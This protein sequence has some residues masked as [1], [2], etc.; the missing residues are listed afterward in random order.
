MSVRLR[1]ALRL[2]EGAAAQQSTRRGGVR[3]GVRTWARCPRRVSGQRH[4]CVWVGRAAALARA[5]HADAHRPTH[6]H[7]LPQDP[8][9]GIAATAPVRP[10][11]IA[12]LAK[13]KAEQKALMKKGHAKQTGTNAATV[14][15]FINLKKKEYNKWCKG[16]GVPAFPITYQKA[17]EFLDHRAAEGNGKGT[18]GGLE[19]ITK[20]LVYFVEVRVGTHT[21]H[22]CVCRC[23]QR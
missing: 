23:T 4:L 12:Y 7:P 1:G 14:G 21:H 17:D 19:S 20:A 16:A 3:E 13:P 8:L 5:L 22:S 18:V 10:A 15:R 2:K 11:L 9:A 6:A